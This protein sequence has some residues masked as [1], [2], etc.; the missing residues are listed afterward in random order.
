MACYIARHNRCEC[1]KTMQV[2]ITLAELDTIRLVQH[3]RKLRIPV[4]VLARS[5]VLTGLDLV[6]TPSIP[7]SPAL[8]P[9]VEPDPDRY[10]EENGANLTAEEEA[11]LSAFLARER[12]NASLPVHKRYD[13]SGGVLQPYLTP[14]YVQP[15]DP[16]YIAQ[17]ELD[18]EASEY[19]IKYR[20]AQQR[21]LSLDNAAD[22]IGPWREA[23][24]HP[25]QLGS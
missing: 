2:R 12:E 14:D 20:V 13:P 10:P 17:R 22:L 6:D 8:R 11:D 4:A 16:E 9:H 19:A 18:P 5:Y 23:N 3:A 15:G 1:E 7:P 25:S 24:T 21:V